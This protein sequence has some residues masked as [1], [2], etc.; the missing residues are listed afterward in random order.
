MGRITGFEPATPGTTNQCSNQLSYI[1]HTPTFR[2]RLP[3]NPAE[4]K[5]FFYI[6]SQDSTTL[7]HFY[8]RIYPVVCFIIQTNERILSMLSPIKIYNVLT[9]KKEEFRPLREGKVAMYACGITVSGDAHIGHAYQSVIFDMITK[10][11]EY[12]GYDVTYVRNYT[13]VD[14]KIIANAAMVGEDP[15]MFAEKFI[16]KTNSEMDALGNTRPTIEPR[17][18]QNITEI[19]DFVRHLIDKGHAY[20]AECGNVYF[21]VKS[22]PGYGKLSHIQVHENE[23]AVRKDLEPGK[24]DSADFALWKSAKP[25]EISWDSPWGKGRP[26]WHI[27]CSAMNLANLGE[28]IDIHGGGRDLIFPHH[29]NEIAQTEALTGKK[30]ANFWIHSGLVKINGQ[31][32]SKSLGNGITLHDMLARYDTD[33]IRFALL[34]NTYSSDIDVTDTFF[35][36]AA[37]QIY[38]M[39]SVMATATANND[40]DSSEL[41]S[42]FMAA[43]DD[44]FN[45][46]AA[47]AVIFKYLNLLHDIKSIQLAIK[48]KELM[49]IFNIL[50]KNPT[51]YIQAVRE[52]VLSKNNVTKSEISAKITE[53]AHLK[54]KRDYVG[55]DAIRSE[56]LEKHIILRDFPTGTTWDVEL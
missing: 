2:G 42:D 18:T 34:R 16:N 28:Q 45:T 38:K 29:E 6:G 43:M 52:K 50:Q 37:A 24:I 20:A 9:H 10:Y 31:K 55:A 17:A 36:D 13:D 51:E 46:S 53:R 44:N 32:M 47:F 25:G 21:S 12:R 49:A 39:Y 26:G 22:F 40:F 48:I 41:V 19:I 11:F 1:R 15:I 54:S 35:T 14:D 30:F 5:Q 23:I 7:V 33:T 27:E 56:L 3:P 8:H 4:C